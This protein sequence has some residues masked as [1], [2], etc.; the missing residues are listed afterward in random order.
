M[1][2]RLTGGLGN[3][4]FQYAFGKA[5][6][7]RTG[8]GVR[9]DSFSYLRDK[10]R[11]YELDAFCISEIRKIHNLE[12]LFY[13]SLY[14]LKYR[15]LPFFCGEHQ[16]F[17]FKDF[18]NCNRNEYY[19]GDWQNTLYFEDVVDELKRELLLKNVPNDISMLCQQIKDDPSAVMLHARR[20][21]YLNN[22]RYV[23]QTI[24][25]YE[26]A[27]SFFEQKLE[28]VKFYVFSDDYDWCRGNLDSKRHAI[29]YIGKEHSAVEDF[30]LM[31]K[32]KNFII[33]NSTFSWWPAYLSGGLCVAPEK[34]YSDSGVNE[35]VHQALLANFICL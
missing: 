35:R 11:K 12:M 13:N 22:S 3:Q 15:E 18:S 26:K 6:A 16:N 4:I 2:V 1:I 34:W 9:F 24:E 10:K 23:V 14:Y 20:G 33:S 17:S 29:I 7:K 32:F 19:F 30:H 25:Y 8:Y 28:N 21:D 27:M 5:L 31:R